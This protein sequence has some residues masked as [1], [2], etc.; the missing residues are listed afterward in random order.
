MGYV[1]NCGGEVEVVVEG[2]GYWRC[3]S[4]G[5]FTE[6]MA[7]TERSQSKR[8]DTGANNRTR[9]VGI[10]KSMGTPMMPPRAPDAGHEAARFGLCPV[11][12]CFLFPNMVAFFPFGIRMFTL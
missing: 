7:G 4:Y 11:G 8:D 10:P 9:K 1:Q 12:F 5:T 6:K 3:Q 2:P